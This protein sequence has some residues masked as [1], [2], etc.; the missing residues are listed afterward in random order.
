MVRRS[1]SLEASNVAEEKDPTEGAE[2]EEEAETVDET[3][4]DD[5]EVRAADADADDAED[6]DEEMDDAEDSDEEAAAEGADAP[7]ATAR[8]RRKRKTGRRRTKKDRGTAGARLA[9]AKAAKAARKAA[10]RAKEREAVAAAQEVDPLEQIQESAFG[11]SMQS[12]GEWA[13][14]NRYVVAAAIG[15]LALCFAVFL[16]YRSYTGSQAAGAAALLEHATRMAEVGVVPGDDEA[17][18]VDEDGVPSSFPTEQARAT[19]ALDAYR[20][21]LDQYPSS[22]A[23]VWARLGVG[24]ARFALGELEE[25]RTA[26]ELA[27]EEGGDDPQVAWM[28]LEGIA[29]TYEATESWTDATNRLDEL[30]RLGE[31]RYAPVAR[32]HTARLQL[33][34]GNEDAAIETL[35]ELVSDL[36]QA[37]ADEEAQEFPFVLA[38]AEL[39][40][41]ALDPSRAPANPSLSGLA[42]GGGGGPPGGLP[43]GIDPETLRRLLQEQGGGGAGE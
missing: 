16:G 15:T 4:A 10:E 30:G 39:R 23:A 24:R 40:L 14:A 1:I 11:Q 12:A 17:S 6:S 33:A 35:D 31:G 36:R 2:T 7:D 25:A 27:L 9:A 22:E 34:E 29:F 43:E 8:T 42:G 18:E 20:A 13:S 38:Q 5:G 32:Y 3:E 37:E 19:A 41:R 28:A 26:Y 21:V